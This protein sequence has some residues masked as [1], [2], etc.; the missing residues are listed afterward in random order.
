MELVSFS[1][2]RK[3]EPFR[4][5]VTVTA[6]HYITELNHT[7][8][9]PISNLIHCAAAGPS[10]VVAGVPG[11]VVSAG[12]PGPTVSGLPPGVVGTADL[13]ARYGHY[14]VLK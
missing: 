7:K 4:N 10:G 3:M 6:L 8:S 11:G 2:S 9:Q 12:V 1:S 13:L 5:E 14:Q